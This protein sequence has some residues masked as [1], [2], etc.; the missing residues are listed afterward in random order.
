MLTT[1]GYQCHLRFKVSEQNLN[2]TRSIIYSANKD[3]HLFH[4]HTHTH[5]CMYENKVSILNQLLIFNKCKT[6]HIFMHKHLV[7]FVTKVQSF[8]FLINSLASVKMKKIMS[9]RLKGKRVGE[10]AKGAQTSLP[11]SDSVVKVWPSCWKGLRPAF[12]SR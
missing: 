11:G 1:I 2:E 7:N 10:S 4:T 3:K 8:F 5:I 9:E 6:S 12:V